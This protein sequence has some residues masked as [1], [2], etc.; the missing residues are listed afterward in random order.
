[1]DRALRRDRDE[2][3]ATAEEM[4]TDLDAFARTTG[5]HVQRV[6][7]L[8]SRLFPGGEARQAKFLHDAA[9]IHIPTDTLSPPAPVPI[10]SSSLLE[11]GEA[12]SRPRPVIRGKLPP[13]N[14]PPRRDNA[15]AKREA[16][17]PAEHQITETH[18]EE[19]KPTQPAEERVEKSTPPPP[20]RTSSPP[21]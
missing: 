16:P 2:R 12:P 6:A 20:S 4:R 13:P 21:S 14:P 8:V 9:A 18:R 17:Q 19:T 1:M 11:D 3:Y 5:P 7:A 15:A 10:A